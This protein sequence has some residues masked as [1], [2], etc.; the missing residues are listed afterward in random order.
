MNCPYCDQA[1]HPGSKFCP[2]CGLPLK[3][4]STVMGGGGAYVTDDSSPSPLLIG[5]GALGAVA[6][7]LG[8]VFFN[9]QGRKR[10]AQQTVRR[11]PVGSYRVPA[12]PGH[13]YGVNLGGGSGP[14]ASSRGSLGLPPFTP[15]IPVRY[16]YTPPP[17]PPQPPALMLPPD[18]PLPPALPLRAITVREQREQPAVT[19]PRPIVPE[20]PV[21]PQPRLPQPVAEEPAE[22][23][24]RATAQDDGTPRP[25]SPDSP[26][27]WDPV[28]EQWARRPGWRPRRQSTAPRENFYTRLQQQR[29]RLYS[30]DPSPRATVLPRPDRPLI[31]ERAPIRPEPL[32]PGLT[33]PDEP[34]GAGDGQP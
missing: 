16:A 1:I 31:F 29:G 2:K 6:I 28:H 30:I 5:A 12:L 33:S 19:P 22:T 4:D 15:G 13:G 23:D 10:P 8:I 34:Q 21:A 27:V 20:I 25:G 32:E 18:D 14:A 7:L 24:A 3:E 9:G 26:W 17:A 11:E